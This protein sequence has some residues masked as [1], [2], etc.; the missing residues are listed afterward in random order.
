MRC[1]LGIDNDG[2]GNCSTCAKWSEELA[3]E[4][5]KMAAIINEKNDKRIR[6]RISNDSN[7]KQD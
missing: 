6:E 5:R 1:L 7:N 2:D 3:E 4:M